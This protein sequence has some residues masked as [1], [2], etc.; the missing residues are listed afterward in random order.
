VGMGRPSTRSNGM[1]SLR[2]WNT[3]SEESE[4]TFSQ[5]EQDVPRLAA[6]LDLSRGC[7]LTPSI[8]A[9]ASPFSRWQSSSVRSSSDLSSSAS[10][11]HSGTDRAE[12][13][14]SMAHNSVS[15]ELLLLV[16]PKAANLV[17]P[18]PQEKSRFATLASKPLSKKRSRSGVVNLASARPSDREGSR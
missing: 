2:N 13:L 3:W 14:F 16:Y 6:R 11:E 17:A 1:P 9:S 15:I 18:F 5:N 7:G 8:A 10:L 4:F 12:N